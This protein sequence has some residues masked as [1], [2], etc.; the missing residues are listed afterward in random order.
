[1]TAKDRLLAVVTVLMCI[2]AGGCALS[3][4]WAIWS[5]GV[6]PLAWQWLATCIVALIG[7]A[8]TFGTISEIG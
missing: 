2:S 8:I 6:Q 3:L 7:L 5:L 4:L 1:M